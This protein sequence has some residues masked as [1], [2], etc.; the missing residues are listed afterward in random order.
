MSA[1]VGDSVASVSP[2]NAGCKSCPHGGWIG[3]ITSGSPN[4]HVNGI[5]AARKTDPGT[6]ACPHGGTFKITS[7]SGDTEINGKAS[8]RVG[9]MVVCDKCGATGKIAAGSPNTF[10]NAA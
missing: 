6:I 3:V 5:P 4:V 2:C 1:R 9:D 10:V 7:G 8:A